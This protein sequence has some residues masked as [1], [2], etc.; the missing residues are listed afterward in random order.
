MKTLNEIV[1]ENDISVNSDL[2]QQVL[3]ILSY[4]EIDIDIISDDSELYDALDYN[5]SLHEIIDSNIDIYYYDLRKW[6]VDN[7]DYIDDAISEGITEG[8]DFHQLIQSG[9]YMKLREEMTEAIEEIW[10]EVK[11]LVYEAQ[12]DQ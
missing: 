11:D 8:N 6:A 2:G 3:D 1:T 4:N 12:N 10:E 9:Q 5:G 7:Y